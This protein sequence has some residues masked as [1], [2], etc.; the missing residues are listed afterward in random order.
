M[1]TSNK[2]HSSGFLYGTCGYE[3]QEPTRN[4]LVVGYS[5]DQMVNLQ[6]R[7]NYEC[8]PY[9]IGRN[10]TK[11]VLREQAK[12][13]RSLGHRGSITGRLR[14]SQPEIQSI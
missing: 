11:R 12:Y 1:T 5:T 10:A 14:A 2:Y 4:Y 3:R 7:A 6:Q 9:N 13:W 8:Q